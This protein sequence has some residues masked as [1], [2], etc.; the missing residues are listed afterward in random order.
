MELREMNDLLTRMIQKPDNSTQYQ[1]Y[2]ILLLREIA[3]IRERM[4]ENAIND[5][6]IDGLIKQEISQLETK[7]RTMLLSI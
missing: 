6:S 1:S 2:I 3:S 7:A 4:L 5:P